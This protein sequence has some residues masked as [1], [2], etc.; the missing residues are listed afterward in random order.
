[1]VGLPYQLPSTFDMVS[2]QGGTYTS[3]QNKNLSTFLHNV[4]EQEKNANM[5]W[6]L[7][8]SNLNRN[9]NYIIFSR[10]LR[11]DLSPTP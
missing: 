3:A 4:L 2:F 8:T 1:M 9:G 5:I 11:V 10:G 6:K 7:E